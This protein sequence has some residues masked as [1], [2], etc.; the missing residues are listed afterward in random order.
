[1]IL[2]LLLYK[3]E[4]WLSVFICCHTMLEA[5]KSII[6]HTHINWYLISVVII[7][8]IVFLHPVPLLTC[9]S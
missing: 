6:V 7:S 4:S 1:M 5:V 2:V 8:L 3:L 9:S